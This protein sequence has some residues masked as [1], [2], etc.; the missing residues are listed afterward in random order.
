MKVGMDTLATAIG[1]FM[2]FEMAIRLQAV[3]YKYDNYSVWGRDFGEIR[4]STVPSHQIMA[5]G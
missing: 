1:A 3:I 4:N 2:P 5:G